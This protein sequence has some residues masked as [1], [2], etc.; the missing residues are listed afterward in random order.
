MPE[1]DISA[2]DAHEYA[3]T[4]TDDSGA[5]TRHT[6]RAPEALLADLGFA[7]AQEAA[8][9]RA[10]LLY[11]LEREPASAVLTDFSLDDI[12]RYFPDYPTEIPGWI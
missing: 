1:L 3:V 6:V 12:S 4:I 5:Q 2:S 10:S 9:V 8:L 7:Q 11:L